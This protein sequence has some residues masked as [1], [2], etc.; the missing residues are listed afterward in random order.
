MSEELPPVGK[1]A[2]GVAGLRA[3]E[4]GR[5]DRLFDDP[6]A[7][8]FFHAGRAIFEGRERHHELGMVFAHQ[9]AIRTR[10][11]DDFVSGGTQT[12]L[13]AAGLDA[14]AFR[15]D[16]PDGARVFEVDLPDVLAFKETVLS[17]KGARPRCQ[18]TTVP[19]DLRD[20]WVAALKNNGFDPDQ[21]TVWLAE[22]LL[23]YLSRDEAE[24]MLTA[25]TELSAPGS[26]VSFEHRPDGDQDGLLERARQFGSE[27]TALWR[28]GL[29]GDAPKWLAEHGWRPETVTVA[30]LSVQYGR[31]PLH[32]TRGGFV[33][34]TR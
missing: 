27:V 7:G 16:W 26:R 8:A 21:P 12:V 29:A 9:V 34:A 32:H 5:P 33:T 30:E 3:L 13:L 23:V 11:F 17:E 14:R 18:R 19:V 31:E 10:F 4:S 15:L 20:D 24:R 22:G 1:T 6:Y 2:V 25:V 28:G